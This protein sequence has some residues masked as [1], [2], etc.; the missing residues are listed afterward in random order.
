[1]P[2]CLQKKFMANRVLEIGLIKQLPEKY[3]VLA[4][5]MCFW[6]LVNLAKA[7]KIRHHRWI[8]A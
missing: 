3:D 5:G 1:M 2:L 4:T 7:S 8:R 6:R